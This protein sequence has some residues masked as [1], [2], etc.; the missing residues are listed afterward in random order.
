MRRATRMREQHGYLIG[1]LGIPMALG[2]GGY[3]CGGRTTL[4][5]GGIAGKPG[6]PSTDSIGSG[7]SGGAGRG[8]ATTGGIGG[9][10][11]PIGGTGASVTGGAGS[12]IP[13][14]GGSAAI[15]GRGG[16]IFGGAGSGGVVS[17]GTSGGRGTGG[18]GGG[19][20][21]D[22][23]RGDAG[24]H[25]DVADAATD[26]GATDGSSVKPLWRSS[27]QPFAQPMGTVTPLVIS[28]WS[29]DRGVF[30]LVRY[31]NDPPVVWSNLGSGW[32]TAYTW[33]EGT[34][35]T[36]GPGRIGLKGFTDGMLLA[37]GFLPCSIHA[38]DSDGARCSGAAKYIAD[39]MP[40]R[41]DLAYA[42][43]SDRI[44]RFDG[45]LWTQLGDPLPA[46]DGVDVFAYALWADS[47]AMAVV[48]LE[49]SVFLLRAEGTPVLQTG[50][51]TIG[52]T[53][54]WGFGSTDIWVGTED[55]RLYH[56]DG[57]GWSLRASFS[58]DS[59]GIIKLWGS[60][61]KLFVLTATT[62]AEWDG[63]LMITL[64]TTKNR[65]VYEDLWGSSAN[66]V[67]LTLFTCGDDGSCT[68][69]VRWFD[70][71]VVGPL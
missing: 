12:G 66:E 46:V 20:G 8:G 45:S 51:P 5:I 70:G 39:V 32:Q 9:A 60:E 56:Y 15:G 61:G 55:G 19:G 43:Y 13:A 38:V 53:A 49:G 27:Y 67:F 64:D 65:G 29:D 42:V 33:P 11:V 24:L 25:V 18:L 36:S 59:H 71:S 37:Y 48:T 21:A 62:F 63:T 2:L 7:E 40:V 34:T 57:A 41:A 23:G 44:L 17:G 4:S 1:L 52:Y 3:G 28:V 50:L 26:S 6:T 22:A 30:L 10:V 58:E 35:M 54:A 14:G 31:D 47:S 69:Q 16:T 68:Y